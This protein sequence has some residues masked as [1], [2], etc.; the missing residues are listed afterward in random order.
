MGIGLD[1]HLFLTATASA[2]PGGGGS[3]LADLIAPV[4]AAQVASGEVKAA[5]GCGK[6][7]EGFTGASFRA[8]KAPYSIMDEQDF[9]F[10][11]GGRPDIT[12]L[13]SWAAGADV[14]LKF[15]YDQTGNGEPNMEGTDAYLIE[16]GELQRF[17]TVVAADG[18]LTRSTTTG[19]LGANLGDNRG[20]IESVSAFGFDTT[21]G[22]EIIPLYS[23]NER[24]VG[25]D[26]QDGLGGNDDDE[27][28]F[29]F[30]KEGNYSNVYLR[31]GLGPGSNNTDYVRIRNGSAV[32]NDENGGFTYKQ[33][34]Q[35][36]LSIGF[37]T[38]E[39]VLYRDTLQD[40]DP[41]PAS[42]ATSITNAE[43]DGCRL[44]LGSIYTNTSG[45]IRSTN[46]ANGMFGGVIIASG[47]ISAETRLGFTN[48]LAQVGQ[49][50]LAT[51]KADLLAMMSEV[52]VFKDSSGGSVTGENGLIT[53]DLNNGTADFVDPDTGLRGHDWSGQDVNN[54]FQENGST[55]A[56]GKTDFGMLVVYTSDDTSND[57]AL[58]AAVGSTPNDL[59][60]DSFRLGMNHSRAIV[61]SQVCG[62]RDPNNRTGRR[63]ERVISTG[64][65][66]V[67]TFDGAGNQPD[68]KYNNA[69]VNKK[70]VYTDTFK[71]VLLTS[72]ILNKTA[73]T[74]GDWEFD[75]V[76]EESFDNL[77]YPHKDGAICVHFGHTKVNSSYD[78]AD[79]YATRQATIMDA[80]TT[81]YIST[82]MSPYGHMDGDRA[83]NEYCAVSDSL[84]NAIIKSTF[85]NGTYNTTDGTIAILAVWEDDDLSDEDKSKWAMNY[86]KFL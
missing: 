31:N 57:L 22:I 5:Y 11:S 6:M 81:S 13:L 72:T 34:A 20:H 16:G 4:T 71:S 59:T 67:S 58:V 36:V 1:L 2:A 77:S 27:Y 84:D 61:Q 17:G 7:V 49:E 18:T 64:L 83:K 44:L 54:Y 28:M 32:Q 47:A 78:R 46:K 62:T 29:H 25:V 48:K 39:L 60:E 10:D 26:D 85:D 73:V 80:T 19:M 55:W 40:N 9:G 63:N 66:E 86:W 53:L 37:N 42:I 79:D 12:G 56:A 8:S 41:M 3:G 75:T 65:Y 14:K 76:I 24:K 21:S 45:S 43:Y 15:W 50:H 82:G 38:S 35:Q 74:G 33:Y 30:A 52:I 68:I 70:L 23:S 51:S 69:A